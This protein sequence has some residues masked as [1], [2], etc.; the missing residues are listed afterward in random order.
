MSFK[1]T[2]ICVDPSCFI[3]LKRQTEF[4]KVLDKISEENDNNIEVI[5]PTIVYDAIMLEPNQKFKKLESILTDWEDSDETFRVDFL[6]QDKFVNN[7]REFLTRYNPKPV[8]YFVSH[9]EKIGTESIYKHEVIQKLGEITGNIIFE[10]MASTWETSVKIVSFGKR[11]ISLIS[12]LGVIIKE[13]HSKYKQRIRSNV[14][15]SGLL[16]ILQF[17]MGLEAARDFMKGLDMPQI[18]LTPAELGL[19]VLL[20]ADG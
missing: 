13:G 6:E 12:K 19:G 15:I 2:K 9:M 7:T 5:I 16:K 20:V 8:K 17:V 11:T 1:I 4:L 18:P 10:L 3:S 14:G